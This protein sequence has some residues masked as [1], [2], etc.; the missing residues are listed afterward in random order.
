M[1]TRSWSVIGNVIFGFFLVGLS[2]FVLNLFSWSGILVIGMLC[3]TLGEMIAFPFSNAFAM[4]RAKRGNQ[5][6][7]MA[8]YSIAFSIS[9]V[10][11][12][13]TGMRAIAG[14]G[15]DSTWY[16]ISALTLVGIALL[17]SLKKRIKKPML[18]VK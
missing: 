7:Y 4:E 13:N 17:F 1:E 14:F 8:L 3:M 16:G 12:H 6:E 18:S 5:G 11:A 10:F 9:H 15:Y 2:F